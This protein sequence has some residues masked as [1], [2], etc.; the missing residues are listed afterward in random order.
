MDTPPQISQ[1]FRGFLPVVIDVETGGFNSKTDALLELAAVTLKMDDFGV[2][3]P[4]EQFD[5]AIRPFDGANMEE[6]ALKFTGI[7]PYCPNR[8][9]L[10]EKEALNNLFKGIRKEMKLQNCTRAILVGHNASFDHNFLFAAIERCEIKRA[11]FH[12]FSTFDT[13]TL[14]G[15]AFGQTVLSVACGAAGINFDNKQAHSALY[16]TLRTAELFCYI[17][18]RWNM[19]GGWNPPSEETEDEFDFGV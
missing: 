13:A 6:A 9:A 14:A 16:D 7:D 10:S 1:R 3:H 19:L 15:L 12:P 18:N 17:V 11:P 8:K 2:M 5:Y 4:K